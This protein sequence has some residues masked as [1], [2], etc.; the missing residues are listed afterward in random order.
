MASRSHRLRL[1]PPGAVDCAV[2][3]L[4]FA[5]WRL[6]GLVLLPL[7]LVDPRLR[8]HAWRVPAPEPGWTW[9]HGDS[10]GEHRAARA[11]VPLLAPGAWRTRASLRTP[12]PG[13]FPAPLDLPFVVERWLDRA[14]PSRLV[15]VEGAL[16]PGWIVGCRRRGIPVAVVNARDSP[17]QRRWRRAGPLARWLLHDVH[18]IEQADT[19]DLKLAA[20]LPPP[21]QRPLPPGCVVGCSTRE[22]D[23]QRIVAA[24][25]TLEPR[26]PLALA[27][28]RLERVPGLA[29]ALEAAGLRV[30]RRSLG[31]DGGDVL[32]IDTMGE[33]ASLLPGA[34]AAVI[35][36]TFDPHIG[37]HSPAE[38]LAAGVPVVHGPEV[39]ANPA[40]FAAA[41]THRAA[42]PAGLPAALQ[43]AVRRG[44]TSGQRSVAAAETARRL[45]PGRTP[46]ERPARPLL[47]PAVPLVRAVGGHRRGWRGRPVRVDVPVISVG[48][49]TAGGSGKTPVAAWLAAR[50]PGAW[51]V[52][53]GHRRSR[54][55][56][57]V[58]VGQ[59]DAAPAHELGDELEMLRRRGLSVVSAP[60]R[61]QG[62]AA[63]IDNGA[64]IIILDDAYQ[65]RR[66]AREL[67]ICCLDGRW[68]GG[69]GPL[70][71]GTRREPWTGLARAD[72]IWIHNRP[73]RP[74]TWV[75]RL[76]DRLRVHS[77][78][79][80]QHWLVGGVKQPLGAVTGAVTVAG[81]LAR[82]EGLVCAVLQLGLEVERCVLVSDHHEVPGVRPGWVLSEKDGARLPAASPQ[83]LLIMDLEVELPL[84]FAQLLERRTGRRLEAPCTPS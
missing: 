73:V 11:L 13:A 14:R 24:W 23:E 54:S 42:S 17:G 34:A 30:G 18:W 64:S 2:G 36:G 44:P 16:W 50:L 52:A 45:P 29:A 7:A 57:A 75:H 37:G 56:P 70:P 6:L 78:P 33:L 38:A 1:P 66:I 48:G 84:G 80:P 39:H 28:R 8:A 32:L 19:G 58:R 47:R 22:G 76:P 82:P 9:L 35:G 63:A 10:A 83:R 43:E 51:V 59:P 3:A 81:G 4:A 67:D 5:L 71:V 68:P 72:V 25:R 74:D 53:R 65:H 41:P 46:P 69:R 79:V 27:P 60:D 15:L 49:L 12:V 40:A 77:R 62:C 31:Q 20:P 61:V 55:G 26:P 21:S